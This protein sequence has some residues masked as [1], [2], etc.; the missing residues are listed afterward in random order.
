M[1][2]DY[3]RINSKTEEND[4]VISEF[5]NEIKSEEKEQSSTF[6]L[7]S[8]FKFGKST[9]GISKIK[10]ENLPSFKGLWAILLIYASATILLTFI[11]FI[12]SDVTMLLFTAALASLM[13]PL[14]MLL[15]FF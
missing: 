4:I 15:F 3:L 14:F 7:F 11:S 1:N 9:H 6:S 2:N 12:T 10:A 8:F 5:K 13:F